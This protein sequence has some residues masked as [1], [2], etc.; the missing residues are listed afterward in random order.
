MIS[1]QLP[2][3]GETVER[4]SEIL[5]RFRRCH[6]LVIGDL[7]LDEY[8]WGDIRRISPEAPVPVLNLVRR[9]CTLGGAGNVA[10]NLRAMGAQVSVF[11]VVGE[12]ATG[13]QILGSLDA[14]QV[15]RSGVVRD[16]RRRSTRKARLMALEHGQQVFRLDEESAHCIDGSVEDVLLDRLRMEIAGADAV[17]CSDYLKGVL[18]ERLL[19]SIFQI[20][21]SVDCSVIVAPKDSTPE[22]Y[23]GAGVL[24]PNM[25]ELAQ[26]V[27]ATTDGSAWLSDAAEQLMRTLGIESL[28][29]TRGAEGM[30]LFEW[31][32]SA[33]RRV[34]IPTVARTVYDVTGAG[35][36]VASVFT[37]VVAAGADRETA[38]RMANVAGGI[39][40][41]KRGTACASVEEIQERLNESKI[42]PL[43][44]ER[45]ATACGAAE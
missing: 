17:L 21:H 23:R 3:I 12:D 11:G 1:I 32:G 29:V 9:E 16:P 43:T 28:L 5:E 25:K 13:D 4:A 34:D 27:K 39:V 24:T 30:T 2:L 14:L 36:T 18:T 42:P 22:K 20:A 44:S 40:V 45:M 26:L 15:R 10:K 35:D 38:A 7:M 41:G 33:V 19:Q 37:L 6:I 8:L 31:L